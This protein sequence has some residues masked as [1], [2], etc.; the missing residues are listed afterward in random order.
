MKIIITEE[1][2]FIIRRINDINELIEEIIDEYENESTSW[3]NYYDMNSFVSAI[4][5]A[6]YSGFLEKYKTYYGLESHYPNQVKNELKEKTNIFIKN[7]VET[8]YGN[9]LRNLYVRK[10]H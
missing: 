4:S 1:Q 5:Y 10:C 6:T 3:C 2:N 9:H 7:L 8:N